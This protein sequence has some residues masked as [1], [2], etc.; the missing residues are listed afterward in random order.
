MHP[1]FRDAPDMRVRSDTPVVVG[2]A[3]IGLWLAVDVVR[4]H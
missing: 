1:K 3:V 4:T 2:A